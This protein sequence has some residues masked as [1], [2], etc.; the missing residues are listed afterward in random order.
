LVFTCFSFMMCVG[1]WGQA[2][3]H[4]SPLTGTDTSAKEIIVVTEDTA[5]IREEALKML[6]TATYERVSEIHDLGV[7]VAPSRMIFTVP[8][9]KSKSMKLTITN[10]TYKK[11]KFQIKFL[12]YMRDEDG[13]L[14]SFKEGEYSPF[15]LSRFIKAVPSVV[16]L[17]PGEVKKVDIIVDLPDVPEAYRSLWCQLVVEQVIERTTL[18]S[19]TP[20]PNKI[21]LGIIPS[22]AF[23]VWVYQNPPNVITSKVE[24][25]DFIFNQDTARG[26]VEVEVKN[27]GNGVA[28]CR[29]YIEAVNM[30]TGAKHTLPLRTFTLLPQQ[31]KRYKMTVPETLPPGK[32]TLT[33]VLDFG[34]PEE[35]QVAEMELE[36]K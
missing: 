13:R 28:S 6:D 26:Y 34:S 24:I 10:D 35:I 19:E 18:L 23:I 4:K 22:M 25:I 9:G 29:S 27:V 1:V 5:K 2:D 14:V 36:I 32:Y 16:E 8:P 21:V 33:C 11:Y 20:D 12:D 15:S 7:A 3:A 31:K 30:K 17:N